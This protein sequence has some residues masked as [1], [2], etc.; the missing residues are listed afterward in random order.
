MP[1]PLNPPPKFIAVPSITTSET[2][3]IVPL[4]SIF[5]ILFEVPPVNL[6]LVSVLFVNV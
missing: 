5:N 1:P 2:S 6:G 3:T 4:E